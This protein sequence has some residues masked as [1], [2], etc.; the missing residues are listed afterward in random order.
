MS[1]VNRALMAALW[2][3]ILALVGCGYQA[4]RHANRGSPDESPPAST[5]TSP[6]A[7]PATP[8]PQAPQVSAGW[9]DD[10]AQYNYYLGY[11]DRFA[12]VAALK[13]DVGGRIVLAVR[14]SRGRSMPNCRLTVRSPGGQVL[15]ERTT[16]ADGRALFFPRERTGDAPQRVTVEA[17]SGQTAVSRTVDLAGPRRVELRLPAERPP[18]AGVPLDVAFIL[19]TTG[20]MGDEIGKLKR[21]LEAIHYQVTQMSPRPDARFA[22][23]CYR[24]RGDA[25][26]TRVAPFTGDIKLF[27]EQLRAVEAAAGGDEPEDLNEALRV[28]ASDL[29]WR[30]DGVRMAFL[31]ADAPP[32]LDYQQKFTYLDFMRQAAARGIKLTTIGASG[33]NQRGEYVFRQLAQYTMGLFVF[34]TYGETGESPG[35]TP[36]TV[37]H[38]TGANW[39]SRNLDAIV[40]QAISA[41]LSHLT[42]QPVK[43]AEDYFQARPADGV[44]NS[45][46]LD[47][48]FA[49]CARQL[50]DY[51][52]LRLAGGTA[53]AVAPVKSAEGCPPGL[54]DRLRGQLTMALSRQASFKLVEREDLAAVLAELDLNDLDGLDG[55][56]TTQP[57]RRLGA[58][59]LVVAKAVRAA[60][61]YDLFVRLVRVATGEV[62]SATVLRIDPRLVDSPAAVP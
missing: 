60:G 44:E 46:V 39:Q 3:T 55:R 27:A 40:V 22:M 7:S 13:L 2:G 54:A 11:L 14:D 43:V 58:E 8:P 25:Y 29:S 6:L 37:S 15:C 19:D 21:T 17:V 16:F 18:F 20:S 47:E 31:L 57:A 45:K 51:S 35:G 23:V 61:R 42:D 33:L 28:A 26:L 24:D 49:E 10:N 34:L 52:Q 59:L 56:P 50:V 1:K 30:P 38:H 5:T 41:E 62:L 12:S 36:W 9:A 48:L 32:H 4:S 53:T